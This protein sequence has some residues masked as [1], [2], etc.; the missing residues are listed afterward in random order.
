MRRSGVVILIAWSTGARF[1]TGGISDT[2]NSGVFSSCGST[3]LLLYE[4]NTPVFVPYLVAREGG[5]GNRNTPIALRNKH[6]VRKQ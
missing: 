3:I 5:Q 1:K 2:L 6:H 4:E